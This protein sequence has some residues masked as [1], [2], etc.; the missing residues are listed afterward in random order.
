MKK[1]LMSIVLL[2]IIVQ[3]KSQ[4]QDPSIYSDTSLTQG[5]SHILSGVDTVDLVNSTFSSNTRYNLQE[6]EV[7]LTLNAGDNFFNYESGVFELELS[8]T[9]RYYDQNENQV[10]ISN[11]R[12]ILIDENQPLQTLIFDAEM[13][14]NSGA[15]EVQVDYNVTTPI[16]EASVPA[17]Y[18]DY[19]SSHLELELSSLTK[20]AI[21]VREPENLILHPSLQITSLSDVD[22][23]RYVNFNWD[24]LTGYGDYPSYELQILKLE[25]TSPSSLENEDEI[26]ARVDWS[27]AFSM[28]LDSPEKQIQL[29]VVQGDGVYLWRVRPIG[30]YYS[31]SIGNSQNY[32]KW[33]AS[34]EVND[35]LFISLSNLPYYAFYLSDLDNNKNWVYERVIA[36]GGQDGE[37][38][39]YSESIN[40]VDYLNY[41]RQSQSRVITEDGVSYV[42]LS[43]SIPDYTGRN[44]WVSLPEPTT[45]TK[46][47][48]YND[49][50]VK[51]EGTNQLY[52]TEHYDEDSNI[53][54]PERVETESSYYTNN[55]PDDRIPSADGYSYV[56]TIYAT[57][58]TMRVVE[59][60]L[61]GKTHA[62]SDDNTS[63]SGGNKTR[64]FY[65]SSAADDELIRIFGEEA[66]LGESV[67]KQLSQDENGLVSVEYV[68]KEGNIIATALYSNNTNNLLEISTENNQFNVTNSTRQ[69]SLNKGFVSSK[70][71]AVTD[72]TT[73]TLTYF[74][75]GFQESSACV[76][77]TVVGD[78]R[79]S[80]SIY[81]SQSQEFFI[82]NDILLPEINSEI[83][84]ADQLVSWIT[85]EGPAVLNATGKVV[86]L[87][88]GE[89]V[90]SKT[91]EPILNPQDLLAYQDS[92][93]EIV[94]AITDLLHMVE[95]AEGVTHDE[96]VQKLELLSSY[97]ESP[98]NDAGIV[99]LL[100]L[101]QGVPSDFTF[102][103]NS[104]TSEM[105]MGLD[106]C[107]DAN[108]TIPSDDFCPF[109]DDAEL[110]RE[111][112]NSYEQKFNDMYELVYSEMIMPL[113]D[114]LSNLS[115]FSYHDVMPGFTY[116]KLGFML[117]NM[118]LSKYY[119]GFSKQYNGTWYKAITNV[120]GEL[121]FAN[122]IGDELEPFPENWDVNNSESDL[123][124]VTENLSYN[125]N[126]E[127]VNKCWL[128]TLSAISH[129]EG[130]AEEDVNIMDS[131]N[132]G[133][134]GDNSEDL[135]DDQNEAMG[136]LVGVML[137][138][139]MRKYNDSDEG[140]VE[141]EELDNLVNVPNMFM[142]CVGYQFADII[143]DDMISTGNPPADYDDFE[144]YTIPVSCN[145]L[146]SVNYSIP[147]FGII[148]NSEFV[149]SSSS[150]FEDSIPVII[151][152]D[153]GG[154]WAYLFPDSIDQEMVREL[155]FPYIF[156]TEW[157]F[158]Y[159]AFN[160]LNEANMVDT[161]GE[162]RTHGDIEHLNCYDTS[163]N[164][165]GIGDLEPC[166]CQCNM[167]HENWDY[168]K[169]YSFYEQIKGAPLFDENEMDIT[170]DSLV[171]TCPSINDLE[172]MVDDRL[173]Y[174][175]SICEER[176]PEFKE[177]IGNALYEACYTIEECADAANYVVSIEQ[178]N[179][180]TTNAVNTCIAIVDSIADK[181]EYDVLD[182]SF[183]PSCELETCAFVKS[184]GDIEPYA[185]PTVTLFQECDEIKLHRIETWNFIPFF[186]SQCSSP[187]NHTYD[188]SECNID[189]EYSNVIHV[190]NN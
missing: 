131:Y 11:I 57:D 62:I 5:Y 154:F 147:S 177:A 170:A 155:C 26:I 187:V 119:T 15:T 151:S 10:G 117:A 77:V 6:S 157:M 41:P 143:D 124:P 184:N 121:I 112:T 48:G 81:N 161:I 80:F 125:Y 59:Q 7:Y 153:P 159:F 50:V 29:A 67:L 47:E 188:G 110:I 45:S 71:I 94:V 173:D 87:P 89:Y 43:Q 20:Y 46:L 104:S 39:K 142:N 4:N 88:P 166:F 158:K 163:Y 98:R 186:Q 150:F 102:N 63:D 38:V 132:E 141:K 14:I 164:V 172:Q 56:R 70:R 72:T 134:N 100:G 36:E 115:S 51:K 130:G 21:D 176:E 171:Q 42:M 2:F 148:D 183:Y 128:G 52:T 169:R 9:L 25:N 83:D 138:R 162:F 17:L 35:T 24:V 136:W 30:N 127:E 90:F 185:N 28:F 61:P 133:T 68:S 120:N 79:L 34:P 129:V 53:R 13:P 144:S 101:S 113:Y 122:Q 114:T 190:S 69:N 85:L 12:N 76:D 84:Y 55:N 111:S 178:L 49:L 82:S 179:M 152:D 105:G 19:I 118:L 99:S 96:L 22:Q 182:P 146:Q 74:A 95:Y 27:K 75:R 37:S 3:V 135:F 108:A 23:S 145:S 109:C 126:P 174:V 137:S 181:P 92:V 139:K 106:C 60:S 156:K 175:R 64:K 1:L 54:N 66:P 16:N 168:I 31:G 103:Y 123:T 160:M 44:A 65:L 8:V 32:G 33:S 165:P 93:S 167:E 40:Y 107:Q 91:L 58:G 97:F 73:F 140:L 78:F 149:N 18:M 86:T 180:L 189:Y 116:E